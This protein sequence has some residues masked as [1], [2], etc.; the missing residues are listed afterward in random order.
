MILLSFPSGKKEI[1]SILSDCLGQFQT[2]VKVLSIFLPDHSSINRSDGHIFYHF[3]KH[4]LAKYNIQSYS[5]NSYIKLL[6]NHVE[7]ENKYNEEAHLDIWRS[8][9]HRLFFFSSQ[10]R[11]Q[12]KVCNTKFSLFV[13]VIIFH[14][15]DYIQIEFN[16]SFL[17]SDILTMPVCQYGKYCYSISDEHWKEYSH[18]GRSSRTKSNLLIL[19]GTTSYFIF[20]YFSFSSTISWHFI[21]KRTFYSCTWL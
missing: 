20:F 16:F 12:K 15:Y 10:T 21:C 13:F 3:F 4:C 17:I 5:R 11:F 8:L 19:I 2:I 14:S 7:N 6:S 18:P 1:T 9:C